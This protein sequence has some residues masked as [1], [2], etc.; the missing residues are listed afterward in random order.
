M[1]KISVI[2]P[3]YKVEKYLS[4]CLESILSQTLTDLEII[5]IN[6]GSPDN[7]LKILEDYA[8]RDKRIV[9]INQSNK[10]IS[11]ARNAGIKVA[12]SEYIGFVDPDDWVEPDFYRDLYNCA[13][14]HDADIVGMGFCSVKNSDKKIMY[15]VKDVKVAST[16]EEKFNIFK[17]PQNNYVW[18]K[19]YSKELIINNDILF[20]EGMCFEDIIWSSQIMEMSNLALMIPNVGY[21]YRYNAQSIVNTSYRSSA[22]LSDNLNA[23]KFQRGIMEKYK[24]KITP[25]YDKKLKIKFLGIEVL[26][27]KEAYDYK[28]IIYL[29]GLKLFEIKTRKMR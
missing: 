26:K 27:I 23:H 1:S 2:I 20:P 8:S 16:V 13:K 21:N 28:K 22:K 3:V 25:S 15:S 17:M 14:L 18:N 29:F 10:G 7:C 6:D 12:K 11:A 5:C 24:M 19:I 9:V 4:Q